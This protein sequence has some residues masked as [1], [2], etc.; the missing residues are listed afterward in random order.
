MNIDYSK[1]S[2]HELAEIL[3]EVTEELRVREEET[4]KSVGRLVCLENSPSVKIL[5]LKV[6]ETSLLRT[7]KELSILDRYPSGITLEQFCLIPEK[8]LRKIEKIGCSTIATLRYRLES[9]GITGA[10]P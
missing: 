6:T 4:K 7:P 1:L 5:R 10:F 2:L 3:L 9:L 8:E